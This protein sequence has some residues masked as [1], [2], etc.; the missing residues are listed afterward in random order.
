MPIS[1]SFKIGKQN[2]EDI[3]LDEDKRNILLIADKF[4]IYY[5]QSKNLDI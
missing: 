5:Q 2:K 1:L 4:K 3:I